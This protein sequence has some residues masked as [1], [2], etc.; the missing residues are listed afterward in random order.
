MGDNKGF[1]LIELLATIT[2]L[3]ILMMIAVPNVIGV[4]NKNKNKTYIED[5][6]KLVSLAEYKIRSN[7][8]YKPTSAS[9]YCFSITFL[10]SDDFGS[11]PNGG[12]YDT[13]KSYVRVNYS[14]NKLNYYVQL[15]EDKSGREYG[16]KE[17][18]SSRLYENNTQIVN[19]SGSTT[20]SGAKSY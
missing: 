20:C 4:V 12:S 19:P 10:G 14:G 11:P 9:Y 15:I 18:A 13:S 16:I 5:A 3:S 7:P 6:K 17:V 1:T 2:L 8:D